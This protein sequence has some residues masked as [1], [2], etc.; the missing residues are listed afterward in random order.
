[1][2][3]NAVFTILAVSALLISFKA[4]EKATWSMDK[5]H[6]KL[7]FTIT[8][9]MVSDVEGWF[10]SF[11]A[12]ITSSAED[13]SDAVVEM[14]AD[15]NSINTENEQRDN[16][17]RSADFFDVAKYPALSFKSKTFKKVS[18]NTYKVTGDLTMHGITKTVELDAICRMGSNPRN[19]QPIAGFK[20]TGTIK[21]ADFGIGPSMPAAVLSDEVSIVANAE[22]GKN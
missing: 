18:G 11:D 21:R 4:P 1:M 13:F 20:I 16:H 9:L 5:N 3:K 14:T 12:K 8:H 10:K 19:Q 2:K 17:L 15:V 22:F 6:A 7:G